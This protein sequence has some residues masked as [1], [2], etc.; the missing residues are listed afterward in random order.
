MAT[1]LSTEFS[2]SP[3]EIAHGEKLQVEYDRL[4]KQWTS[5]TP[6]ALKEARDKAVQAFLATP[7]GEN[8]SLLK[9]AAVEREVLS[10]LATDNRVRGV[11]KEAV[12]NYQRQH[13]VPWAKSILK[14]ALD[15]A[16][17]KLR[18]VTAQESARHLELTGEPMKN[19]DIVGV[20]TRPVENLQQFQDGFLSD[21]F[22][23]GNSPTLLLLFF[24]PHGAK[25]KEQPENF[26]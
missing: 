20:A 9:K 4:L 10:V 7:T 16:Q 15:K 13:I 2:L 24:S 6:S 23:P 21:N 26:R 25:K 18:E 12:E 5:F 3:E 1:T 8:L 17:G 14:R 11:T 19:S 22:N